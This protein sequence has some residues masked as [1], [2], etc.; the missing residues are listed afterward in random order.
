MGDLRAAEERFLEFRRTGDPAALAAVFDAVAPPLLLLAVHLTRDTAAAEDLVQ[1]TFIAAMQ[2]AADYREDARLWPWLSGILGHRAQAH[3]R[4]ESRRPDPA[5]LRRTAPLTPLQNAQ[6]TELSEQLSN[7]VEA[8]PPQYREVLL[9]RLQHGLSSREIGQVL[10]RSPATVRTQLRRGLDQLRL[11]LSKGLSLPAVLALEPGRGLAEVKR[12]VLARLDLVAPASATSSLLATAA[13]VGSVVLMKKLILCAVVAAAVLIAVDP[14]STASGE[15][16]PPQPPPVATP[17]AMAQSGQERSTV[18]PGDY[19]PRAP[20]PSVDGGDEL[21]L[22]SLGGVVRDPEARPVAGVE[23]SLLCRPAGDGRG[24]SDRLVTGSDGSFASATEFPP[25][26]LSIYI[27]QHRVLAVRPDHI[28]AG[29]RSTQLAIVAEPAETVSGVV[30]DSSGTPLEGAAVFAYGI[31]NGRHKKILGDGTTDEHGQFTVYADRGRSAPLLRLQVRKPPGLEQLGTWDP[32][33]FGWGDRDVELQHEPVPTVTIEVVEEGTGHPVTAFVDLRAFAEEGR[34]AQ[35]RLPTGYEQGRYTVPLPPGT[36]EVMVSERSGNAAIATVRMP[37]DRGKTIRVPLPTVAQ[38]R[39]RVVDP[40]GHPLVGSEVSMLQM[41]RGTALGGDAVICQPTRSPTTP[42]RDAEA[43]EL[44][45]AETDDRGEV[46]VHVPQPPDTIRLVVTGRH[47]R[48]VCD[49]L[50]GDPEETLVV[51]AS[52]GNM[53]RGTVQPPDA[54]ARLGGRVG[55]LLVRTDDPQV[56]RQAEVGPDG[57]FAIADVAP[58]AYTARLLQTYRTILGTSTRYSDER[59]PWRVTEDTE[60]VVLHAHAALAAQE[61]GRLKA[62]VF[63]DGAPLAET[64]VCLQ[65]LR[66]KNGRVAE[67]ERFGP[68]VTDASGAFAADF[69]MPGRYL[70]AVRADDSAEPENWGD[71]RVEIAAGVEVSAVFML[72]SRTLRLRLLDPTGAPAAARLVRIDSAIDPRAFD[73]HTDEDGW[74]AFRGLSAGP[75][76][77]RTETPEFER[78]SPSERRT[79][80]AQQPGIRCLGAVRF[81]AGETELRRE[82]GY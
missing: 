69:V 10:G 55:V 65:G 9:L 79:E 36:H 59:V 14:W 42:P 1:D 44:R 53:V 13:A 6:A 34:T 20:V 81:E 28:E 27:P 66:T 22:S 40:A 45:S 12:E 7:V 18:E 62:R 15:A 71:E 4:A 75:W 73:A 68:F 80:A 54:V 77:V 25:G 72:V 56:E 35:P 64:T 19:T 74:V 24:A 51:V 32:R 78:L 2:S 11:R 52:L 23:I 57:R 16:V 21:P 58:G 48:V 63:V 31:E 3:A 33:V 37:E 5:R 30:V 17:A 50:R 26:R 29:A 76:E 8:M 82:Y 60:P 46:V 41:L 39:V 70:L 47:R 43:L 67:S 61:P 38:R 49:D